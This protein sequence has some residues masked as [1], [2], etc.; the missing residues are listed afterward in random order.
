MNAVKLNKGGKLNVSQATKDVAPPA[1]FHWMTDR[2]RYFLMKGEYA[3]H[4][5]AVKE[6]KFKLASHKK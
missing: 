1:G 2:G 6:A 4:P 5:G 3:D